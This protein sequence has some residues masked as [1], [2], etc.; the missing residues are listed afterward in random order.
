VLSR[1]KR[2]ADILTGSEMFDTTIA[3]AADLAAA[4]MSKA[5]AAVGRDSAGRI[6]LSAADGLEVACDRKMAAAALSEVLENALSFSP[7]GQKVRFGIVS[8][9]GGRV[10]FEIADRGPGI[11]EHVL[12]RGF[13]LSR[14]GPPRAGL[15]LGLPTAK[16]IVERHGGHFAMMSEVGRGTEVFLSFPSRPAPMMVNPR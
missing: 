14:L 11:P 4:A 10:R 5:E 1:V 3:K 8:A 9:P 7:A 16:M 2:T 12:E 15:G 13:D 6:E